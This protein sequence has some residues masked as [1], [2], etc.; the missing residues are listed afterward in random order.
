MTQTSWNVRG[1]ISLG[2]L[3]LILSIGFFV[4]LAFK[5][6]PAY[7]DHYKVKSSLD[8]LSQ[9]TSLASKS[10]SEIL[11]MLQKR[12]RVEDITGISDEDIHIE[13]DGDSVAIR[14]EY[15]VL[16]PIFGN[17]EALIRFDDNVEVS[18]R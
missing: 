3:Y 5:L 15:Q 17:V 11:S 12:W 10:R 6:V 9:D 8:S 13:R 4:I 18:S 1:F 2:A 14:V 16:K 7:I